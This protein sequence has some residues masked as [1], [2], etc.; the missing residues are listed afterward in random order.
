MPPALPA[1]AKRRASAGSGTVAAP[2]LRA[3]CSAPTSR[4][5]NRRISKILVFGDSLTAGF[6]LPRNAAFPEQL[7]RWLNKHAKTAT[8]INGGLSGDTTEGGV[9]RLDR[10]LASHPDL[11]IL[12]LGT[13]DALRGIPPQVT[14]ANL[15]TMIH[16]IRAHGAESVLMGTRAPTHWGPDYQS[17]FDRVYPKLAMTSGVP[18]YPFFLAGISGKPEFVLPDGLHPN[19]RGVAELVSRIAPI[20]AH[21]YFPA[22]HHPSR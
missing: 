5:G 14:S 3:N 6:R 21:L 16:K 1:T 13:N 9:N 2:A 17:E 18:L 19:Q 8:V 11:V 15:Q 10:A 4:E 7:E 20:I 22:L 12:E